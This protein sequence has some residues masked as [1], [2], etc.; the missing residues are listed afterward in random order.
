M[1]PVDRLNV[2]ILA[3]MSRLATTRRP[4]RGA[5]MLEYALLGTIGVVI[6]VLL[7]DQ[8]S[9]IVQGIMDRISSAANS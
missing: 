4:A 1:S 5:G 8:I 7:R 6:I 2:A 3:L 9:S